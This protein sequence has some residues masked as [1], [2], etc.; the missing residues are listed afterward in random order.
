MKKWVLLGIALLLAAFPHV[1]FADSTRTPLPGWT[2]TYKVVSPDGRY[3]LIMRGEMTAQDGEE[4]SPEVAELNKLLVKYPSSGLYKNDGSTDPLWVMPYVSWRTSVL[5]S[6]DGHHLVVWG[7][8]PSATAT[9]SDEALTFYEDGNVLTT[10]VVSDLVMDPEGLPH[11]A[12]HYRWVLK[13]A[14][15]DARGLL[16]VE[17]YNHEEYTFDMST[18][19]VISAVVPTVT[20]KNQVSRLRPQSAGAMS[21]VVPNETVPDTSNDTITAGLLL[22]VSSLTVVFIGVS[23][24]SANARRKRADGLAQ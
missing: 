5:L 8:W 11:S 16:T 23:I 12:S 1:T 18:G 24:L 15:D 13:E 21:T 17:T 7:E 6:S 22:S 10:Y 4:V 19:K 2:G 14:F 20:A 9:Y 3:V